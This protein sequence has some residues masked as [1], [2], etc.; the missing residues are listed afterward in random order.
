M[1]KNQK[2][3][4]VKINK[5]SPTPTYAS[6][7][8]D[9][10]GQW[11]IDDKRKFKKRSKIAAAKSYNSQQNNILSMDTQWTNRSILLC[12]NEKQHKKRETKT[13]LSLTLNPILIPPIFLFLSIWK[14]LVYIVFNYS[15][16]NSS[17]ASFHVPFFVTKIDDGQTLR[18]IIWPE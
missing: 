10:N 4:T 1:K 13:K 8:T 14:W 9:W 11:N 2:E 6:K 5:R 17:P 18:C 3:R 15:P 16:V 12:A 7:G